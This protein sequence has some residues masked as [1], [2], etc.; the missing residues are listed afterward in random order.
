MALH[1]CLSATLYMMV[2]IPGT[3]F[4]STS[5]PYIVLRVTFNVAIVHMYSLSF[6]DEQGDAIVFF[7]FTVNEGLLVNV[8]TAWW[9]WQ[10]SSECAKH[11]FPSTRR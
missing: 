9:A 1:E 8:F 7:L 4:L 11:R 5:G 10:R 3:G 6:L 2:G